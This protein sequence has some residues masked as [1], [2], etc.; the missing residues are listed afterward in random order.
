M[1]DIPAIKGRYYIRELVSQGEHEHQDF[2]FAITDARKIARSISAFA[3]NDGGHLLVGVKDNGVIA[4][5]RSEEDIY[6][7]ET[8]AQSFC[9]PEVDVQFTAFKV[10]PGVVVYRATIPKHPAP[11]VMVREAQ[12]VLK[13]YYRVKD[14]NIAADE[15]QLAGWRCASEDGGALIQLTESHRSLL[16]ALRGVEGMSLDHVMRLTH[17]SRQGALEMVASLAAAGVVTI[18]NDGTHAVIRLV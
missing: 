14:E 8:A 11:P 16:D 15:M 4:G 1:K 18:V 13:A 9:S 6:M 12:G 10:D 17:L 7:I 5:V 2:K 3:N